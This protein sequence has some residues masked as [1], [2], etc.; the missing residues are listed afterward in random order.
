MG[1]EQTQVEALCYP[2]V[3][4]EV[5]SRIRW[6]VDMAQSYK[7]G[8]TNIQFGKRYEEALRGFTLWE[9]ASIEKTIDDEA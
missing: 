5:G 2:E 8:R 1:H 7:D 4:S 9:E 3:I 6:G